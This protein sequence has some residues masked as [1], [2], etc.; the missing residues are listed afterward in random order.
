MEH[1]KFQV[2]DAVLWAPVRDALT[3]LA[4]GRVPAE[5]MAAAAGAKLLS[6]EKG[7]TVRVFVLGLAARRLVTR[8][9]NRIF[10]QRVADVVAPHQFAAG[11]PG[12]AETVHKIAMSALAARESCGIRSLDVSNAH[13]SL[14]RAAAAEEVAAALPEFTPWVLP[15]LGTF[16]TCP[17]GSQLKSMQRE[18]SMSATLWQHPFMFSRSGGLRKKQKR[19]QGPKTHWLP[20]EPKEQIKQTTDDFEISYIH[21][22]AYGQTTIAPKCRPW[23]AQGLPRTP[24]NHPRITRNLPKSN[25]RDR[26]AYKGHI[27]PTMWAC[28]KA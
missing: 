11:Q 20:L 28:S 17:M 9:V 4:L 27:K 2:K 13:G 21:S 10:K 14:E 8:A 19:R 25:Q 3:D 7:D 5:V 16:A 1:Y 26:G 23:N 24:P 15:W 22:G 6:A 12:G 18:E